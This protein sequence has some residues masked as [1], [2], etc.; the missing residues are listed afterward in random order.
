MYKQDIFQQSTF[1]EQTAAQDDSVTTKK[2]F[3]KFA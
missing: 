3:N 1:C 2:I